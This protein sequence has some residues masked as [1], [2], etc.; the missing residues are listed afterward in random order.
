[1]PDKEKELALRFVNCTGCHLFLTG[2]AGTGKTTLLKHIVENTYKKVVVT[3]PTGIAAINAGGV[4]LHSLFQLP[5]GSFLP[6]ESPIGQK[7]NTIPIH[8]PRNLIRSIRFFEAKRR[9]IQELELLI[10]DEVSMLRADLLD[11]IDTLLRHIRR[12]RSI[13]FG[14]V[15]M[16]FIGDLLQLPPVVKN[17]EWT[18]LG[19]YYPSLFFFHARVLKHNPPV[20]I[21]LDHIYRQRDHTFIRLLNKFRNNTIED[22]DIS[23]LNRHLQPGYDIN[24]KPGY[25]YLTTHNHKAQTINE[26]ALHQIAKTASHF[27]AIIRGDFREK[28]YPVDFILNVKEGAQVMFIKN[29]PGGEQRYFNGKIGFIH[30]IYDDLIEVGF[31]D[32]SPDVAVKRITWENK[33]YAVNPVTREISEEITGTFS[34]FPLKLAWAITI[35]KSQGLTF[36]KAVIDVSDAFAHG[37]IYVALSRLTGLKGLVLS[38]PLTKNCPGP[39]SYLQEFYRNQPSATSIQTDLENETKRFFR[40]QLFSAFDF[41]ELTN[42]INSHL[43]SYNKKKKKKKQTERQSS[44][45]LATRLQADLYAEKAI[46]ER[47]SNYLQKTKT[48]QIVIQTYERVTK[49]TEYFINRLGSMSTEIL[50]HAVQMNESQA[51]TKYVSDL[52]ALEDAIHS[53]ILNLSKVKSMYRAFQNNGEVTGT[54]TPTTNY[55]CQRRKMINEGLLAGKLNTHYQTAGREKQGIDRKTTNN[56]QKTKTP[57]AQVSGQL[58]KEGKSIEEIATIRSLACSTIISHMVNCVAGGMLDVNHFLEQRKLE[59]IRLA[60]KKLET[61]NAREIMSVLGDE[62]TYSDIH[63]ALACNDKTGN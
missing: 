15:Q 44:E 45:N 51:S 52:L 36:E 37:Q 48:N 58:Y 27:E 10:I 39:D 57:S 13:P 62:F 54:C 49:A 47:F 38:K 42:M 1:M 30:K 14:G 33:K 11:A 8:T 53:K 3:A 26:K 4:T 41:R 31:N 17:D 40:Q 18:F 50:T 63:F 55:L 25:I 21:E 34:H 29:D 6:A 43:L 28:H 20:Y 59:Q 35:H 22:E 2:R 5:L 32:G 46:A 19:K 23:L 7:N 56:R 12:K 61:T 9:L 16:L 24:N 60:A